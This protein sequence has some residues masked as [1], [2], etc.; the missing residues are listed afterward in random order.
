M[1]LNVLSPD[2]REIWQF[3]ILSI[4]CNGNIGRTLAFLDGQHN[5]LNS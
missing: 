2:V 3:G 5:A 4:A 1:R